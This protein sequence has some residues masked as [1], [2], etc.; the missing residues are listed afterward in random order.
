MCVFA[1][2]SQF[3]AHSFFACY[4]LSS[5]DVTWSNYDFW[6]LFCAENMPAF[7]AFVLYWFNKIVE[8][9]TCIQNM[10][11]FYLWRNLTTCFSFEFFFVSND[12][13]SVSNQFTICFDLIAQG[14]FHS[15]AFVLLNW[16]SLVG[17][18]IWAMSTN[19]LIVICEHTF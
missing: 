12:N 19:T 13:E 2:L 7:F 11:I 17:P 10:L 16:T 15:V 1:H 8:I 9:W 18:A 3:Q 5:K 4:A 6:K 14:E